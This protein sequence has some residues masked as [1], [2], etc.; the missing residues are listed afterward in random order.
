[1]P[2]FIV[3]E[4]KIMTRVTMREGGW[5]REETINKLHSDIIQL[6]GKLKNLLKHNWR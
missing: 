1:M 2:K 4:L 5:S 3:S 6:K